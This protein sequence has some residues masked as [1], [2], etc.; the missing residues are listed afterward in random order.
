MRL[1]SLLCV[2][3]LVGVVCG[4][5]CAWADDDDDEDEGGRGD[6]TSG[7]RERDDHRERPAHGEQRKEEGRSGSGSSGA[8]APASNPVYTDT[9]AS[10]HFA[11][12]PALLPARSWEKLLAALPDHFGETVEL[13]AKERAEISAY[14]QANAAEHSQAGRAQRILRSV[15]N[16]TPQRIT[17]IPYIRGKHDEVS[18]AV[19]KRKAIGSLSNCNA[20]HQH[21][22]QGVFEEHDVRIP[23]G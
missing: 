13:D 22:A 12:P 3:T 18:A 14:L 21:A 19:L 8:L 4:W 23:R 7:R 5:S 20:C 9:C 15:G 2:L 10:C 11:Y 6:H 1:R 16:A 17:E